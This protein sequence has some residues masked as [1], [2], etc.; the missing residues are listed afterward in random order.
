MRSIKDARRGSDSPSGSHVNANNENNKA[1]TQDLFEMLRKSGVSLIL[2]VIGS[3][4]AFGMTY[5][6]GRGL[7]TFGAGLFFLSLA[8]VTV[9][10][11]I[12]R[13]GLDPAITRFVSEAHDK[14]DWESINGIYARSVALVLATSSV[15]AICLFV[16]APSICSVVFS[17]PLLVPV[18]RWMSLSIVGFALTWI[19]SHFFQGID[20]IK[21]FQVFQNLGVTSV[22]LVALLVTF[23]LFTSDSLNPEMFAMC[24]FVAC[25]YTALTACFIWIRKHPWFSWRGVDQGWQQVWPTILPLWLIML[26]QQLSNWLPQIS[27]GVFRQADEVGIYNAAFRVANLTSLVLLGVNSVVFP[28][29]AA[30]YSSGE[31]ERLKLIAQHSVRLMTFACLPFLALLMFFPGPILS[32]FGSGFADGAL[33]LQIISFGQLVNVLTGSVGGLLIM[34][35]NQD[36]GLQC[37]VASFFAMLLALVFLTPMLG[38]TGTAIAQAV[39]VTVNMTLLTYACRR[40]LGFAP[41]GGLK[42]TLSARPRE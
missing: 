29:F 37:G 36:A 25:S 7:G 40:R 30:L 6:V 3:V 33:T 9:A 27:L 32:L 11:T 22:F 8:I 31:L 24:F 42:V 14:R 38:A 19:H 21:L 5:V 41:V 18:F 26:L 34:T 20:E 39:G 2:K 15:A 1:K 13:L 23:L 4:V 17:E 16:A 28:K 12:C 35:G 10:S